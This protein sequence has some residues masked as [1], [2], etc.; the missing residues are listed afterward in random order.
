[1]KSKIKFKKATPF[2]S[3]L[4]EEVNILL[5]DKVIKKSKQITDHKIL[6]LFSCFSS[7]VCQSFYSL[8][9]K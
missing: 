3:E 1:M 9:G 7:F 2:Y 8:Y 4:R 6:I 5:T